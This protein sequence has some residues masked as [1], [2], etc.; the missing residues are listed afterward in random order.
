MPDYKIDRRALMVEVASQAGPILVREARAALKQGWF[1]PAVKQLQTDFDEHPVTQEIRGG[2]DSPNISGTLT[3]ANIPYDP[4]RKDRNAV[5]NLWGFIGFP[6]GSEPLEPIER[7]LNPDD[8]EGP[9][10]VYKGR[11]SDSLTFRFEV[12]APDEESIYNNTALPWTTGVG[13]VSWAKRVE[14][15]LPGI[16]FFLNA[17]RRKGSRSGEGVQVDNKL[18]GGSYR[19]TSYLSKLFRVFLNRVAGK[20]DGR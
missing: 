5:P 16:G 1:D 12:R 4:E 20:S 6:A 19:P 10:M 7:R 15:G 14:V 9:Q 11:D 17:L 2:P 18:R 3:N 8:P 13:G